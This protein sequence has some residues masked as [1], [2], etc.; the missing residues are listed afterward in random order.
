MIRAF[1]PER[2]TSIPADSSRSFAISASSGSVKRAIVTTF[3]IFLSFFF[4]RS[5]PIP[6][7]HI[8]TK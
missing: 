5:V 6:N 3:D 7:S 2:N 8:S 1:S 4:P